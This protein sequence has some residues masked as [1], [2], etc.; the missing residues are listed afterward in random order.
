LR[1]DWPV[2]R[3]DLEH[4]AEDTR[5]IKIRDDDGILSGATSRL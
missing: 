2:I 1:T 4:V 5:R 3:I